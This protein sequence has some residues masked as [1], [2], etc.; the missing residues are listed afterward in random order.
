[1]NFR[2]RKHST[3][4]LLQH[5]VRC[6]YIHTIV[7]ALY[8]SRIKIKCIKL[9]AAKIWPFPSFVKETASWNIG[10]YILE[11]DE[12]HLFAQQISECRPNVAP[13]FYLICS[14]VPNA[15]KMP[16]NQNNW[17]FIFGVT[18][19]QSGPGCSTA[20]AVQ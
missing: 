16:C 9:V 10:I 7:V 15:Q 11:M 17:Y 18:V 3:I 5:C 20:V 19:L 14:R 8:I 13:G 2:N 4:D 12:N 1:M 6:I